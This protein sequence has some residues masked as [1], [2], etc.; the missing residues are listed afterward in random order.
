MART[1]ITAPTTAKRG[2]IIELRTLIAHPME[3]GFRPDSNGQVK[4]RDLIRR[5]TCRYNNE[6][7]FSAEL[8]AATAANPY[9]AFFTVATESGT[10]N[11]SWEGDN[12]FAQ[13]ESVVISVT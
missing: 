6:V 3:T 9:I 4:P 8:F 13:S 12:G 1:L 7:I 2:D 11:F 5:F 10:L